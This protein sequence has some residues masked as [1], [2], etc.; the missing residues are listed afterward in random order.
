VTDPVPH[1]DRPLPSVGGRKAAI[2][3]PRLTE[4]AR[5]DLRAL[6]SCSQDWTCSE[7]FRDAGAPITAL[8]SAA[9][10]GL[11][12]SG[13]SRG[14]L[15]VWRAGLSHDAF[16]IAVA[17]PIRSLCVAGDTR[18]LIISP[19][20]AAIE[21]VPLTG[22]KQE[23]GLSSPDPCLKLQHERVAL[24]RSSPELS[25]VT[26]DTGAGKCFIA[27]E[28]N[29]I[30]ACEWDR[31][32]VPERLG[33]SPSGGAAVTAMEIATA[34]NA[35]VVGDSEGL[36][37]VLRPDT[38]AL[39]W[40][41]DGHAWPILRFTVATHAP[42]FVSISGDGVAYQWDI[43]TGRRMAGGIAAGEERVASGCF[44]SNGNCLAL[45]D[46]SGFICIYDIALMQRTAHW[47]AHQG[48]VSGLARGAN[49][50]LYSAGQDG[51]I[52]AWLPGAPLQAGMEP[53][54]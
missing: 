39:V 31:P 8:V 6:G 21:L 11:L 7:V 10:D 52:S 53:P 22:P 5:A 44:L 35:L 12:A 32:M 3:S 16:E 34:W 15:R 47:R 13:D 40:Q 48:K 37:S 14:T 4:A 38:G 28:D 36:I 27:R 24:L 45:G 41:S 43:Q 17:A 46:Y 54:T 9:E 42:V 29:S 30:W 23:P 49:R 25:A 2:L 26:M 18:A 50:L 33:W 51:K 19:S 1:R 20:G